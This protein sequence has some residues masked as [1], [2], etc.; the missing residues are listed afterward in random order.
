VQAVIDRG[1]EAIKRAW[2]RDLVADPATHAWV[3]SLYRAGELYPDTVD[4]YFP[5]AHAPWPWL[6]EALARHRDDER[7][8]GGMFARAVKLSGHAVED[9][10]GDDVFNH[11][12]RAQTPARWRVDERD[13]PD[14]RR[15]ALAHFLAHAHHLE[16]R[17]SRSLEMH[18]EACEQGRAAVAAKVVSAVL[19]DE[20]RHIGYTRD[21]VREL[22]GDAAARAVMAHHRR[23]EARA[24]LVFSSRQVARFLARFEARATPSRK[25]LYRMCAAMQGLAARAV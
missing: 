22:V 16:L 6:A 14:A 23:A 12:I 2:H 4:D 13:G 19:A 18:L 15:L 3:L 9:F 7:R 17:V 24:D 8:H 1:V 20:H 21:A 25:A 11:V 5:V 10:A